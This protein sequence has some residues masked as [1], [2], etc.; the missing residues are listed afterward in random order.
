MLYIGLGLCWSKCGFSIGCDELKQAA[1]GGTL[2]M[3]TATPRE[4]ILGHQWEGGPRAEVSIR[5]SLSVGW[6]IKCYTAIKYYIGVYIL[7]LRGY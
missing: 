4:E 2:L 6:G 1:A 3:R 5:H 7:E